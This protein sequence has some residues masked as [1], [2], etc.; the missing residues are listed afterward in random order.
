MGHRL[1]NVRAQSIPQ[2]FGLPDI[3]Y[4]SAAALEEVDSGLGRRLV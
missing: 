3:E 4:L 2:N 1:M